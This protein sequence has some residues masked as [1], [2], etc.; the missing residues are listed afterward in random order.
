MDLCDLRWT[1]IR[2]ICGFSDAMRD[3]CDDFVCNGFVSWCL[4]VCDVAMDAMPAMDL[5]FLR[6]MVLRRSASVVKT[7]PPPQAVNAYGGGKSVTCRLST[8]L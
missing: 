6:A 5:R 7:K 2:V 4:R 1:T 3:A 8:S